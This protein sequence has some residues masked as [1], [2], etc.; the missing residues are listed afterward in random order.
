MAMDTFL[1]RK[2]RGF[3]VTESV[4]VCAVVAIGSALAYPSVQRSISFYKLSSGA[5]QV[6]QAFETAKFEAIRAN[7]SRC[8]FIDVANN[9]IGIGA[10]YATATFFDLPRD[11]RIADDVAQMVGA[12]E[13]L[14]V[15]KDAANNAAVING[16]NNSGSGNSGSGNSGS[17]NSG[18]GNSGSGS[19]SHDCMKRQEGNSLCSTSLPKISGDVSKRHM[20][21]TSKGLPGVNPGTVN[22][23]YLTN[24]DQ[25]LMVIA[26]T[27]AGSVQTFKWN[28]NTRTW[29]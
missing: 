28:K 8:I 7:T 1:K 21:F 26:V 6:S 23:V 13:T 5:Q 11:V 16:D 20:A 18:S 29:S 14:P 19:N 22:W 9:R 3:S 4:V 15:I 24:N 27:S 2:S 25:E 10:S 17:G 12:T